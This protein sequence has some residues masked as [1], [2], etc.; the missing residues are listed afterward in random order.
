[1]L[2]SGYVPLP[3]AVVISILFRLVLTVGELMWALIFAGLATVHP[4]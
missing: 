3:V 1:V 4:D 2:L